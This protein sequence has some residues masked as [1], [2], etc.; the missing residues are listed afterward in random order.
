MG[1]T[2]DVV[3]HFGFGELVINIDEQDEIQH[4]PGKS[5]IINRSRHRAGLRPALG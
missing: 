2:L 5:R 3:K 1:E 4:V